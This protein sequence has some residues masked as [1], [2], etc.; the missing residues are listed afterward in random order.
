MV[1]ARKAFRWVALA[2]IALAAAFVIAFPETAGLAL[3]LPLLALYSVARMFAAYVL[4]L[5]FAIAYG[6]TMATNRKAAVVLLP[7]L[8]IL[9]SVPILGFFPA[10]LIFFVTTFQGQPVGLEIAVV[11]LIF[12][13][14][15]WNMAFGVYE[16]VSTIPQD[17]VDA[18]KGFGVRDWLKF[19]R[20][21]F[22][23]TVPKL[24]YN[25]M[26]SWSNGWFF[27]V[28]SEIFTAF[29]STYVRPGLGAFIADRGSAGDIAGI[30]LGLAVLAAVV[31]ALDAVLWRPLSVWSE[32]FRIETTGTGQP[33]PRVPLPYIRLTWLPRFVRPR[34]WVG[35]RLR[36]LA[37]GY[38]R[39]TVRMDRAA[40]AH[41]RVIRTVRWVDLALFAVIFAL[42]VVTGIVGLIGLLLR[43]HSPGVSE[44]PA[45]TVRSLARL[46]LAYGAALA[47]TIPAAVVLGRSPRASRLLTPVIEV[48]ASL[49]ATA[50]LPLIIGFAIFLTPS[51]GTE[52][53]VAAFLVALFAMQWYLLFNLIAGVRAI[54]GD[55]DEAARSFGLKGLA[56]W[57]RLIFPA[58][59]PSLITGSI[60][61][62]GAGWNAL[63]VS[64]YIQF[65]RC[66]PSPCLYWTEGLG[67]LM[68]RATF[69]VPQLGLLP[70]GELLLLSILTMVLVVLAMNKL[71]WRPLFRRASARY[72]LEV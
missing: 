16:S 7:L 24:V 64:E 29:G 4:S 49:P 43:P 37:T 27:L 26:L 51:S 2:L 58:I 47:W 32:R 69:G 19:R 17:L 61:A 22:P 5:V 14:M 33:V 52:A 25:S 67:Y 72:R 36:P 15:S 71:V 38:A 65:G 45:A 34:R 13:S 21:V 30:F 31:V 28:A 40:S 42:V 10:A 48:S 35:T 39:L 54:P 1:A 8:D 6:T 44:I 9:Q 59:A 20:L 63:I 11:F 41:R 70:D 12:T 60:T 66:G 68:D 53:E 3:Q 18:A 46:A 62:W 57:K 56:F 55:L 50:L 23:A